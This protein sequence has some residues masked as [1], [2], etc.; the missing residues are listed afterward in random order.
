MP[1]V[2]N[3]VH[4]ALNEGFLTH[5]PVVDLRVSLVD[6]REHPVDSSEMAFKLAGSQALKP[7]PRR[8]IRCC[9][10]P[11]SACA[12]KSPETYTGDLVSD[13]NGKRAHVL[14]ITPEDHGTVIDAQ[15]P[16]AE[17]LRYATDLRSLTQGRATFTMQFD[18]YA[19]VPEHDR[20]R[21]SSKPPTSLTR[22]STTNSLATHETHRR[23]V[24]E[25][26]L[27]CSDSAFAAARRIARMA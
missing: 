9:S 24:P 10:S 12:S 22:P 26:P 4:E 19:E 20:Q 25:T 11:S 1:A 13:L 6:G 16:L 23:G 8:P 5:N 17:M 18:H 15:A 3:G 21:R 2:E 14:G 27:L 7:A